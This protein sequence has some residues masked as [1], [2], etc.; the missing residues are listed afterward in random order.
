MTEKKTWDFIVVGSGAG[1]MCAALKMRAAGK[2]VLIIEK[3]ELLGGTTATSGGVMW[4]PNNRFM[5]EAGVS[6]CREDAIRYLDTVVGDSDSTP[7]TSSKR[8]AAYVDVSNEMLEFLID[9]GLQFRRVPSW[10]DYYEALGESI[11]GRTVAPELFDLN[12][13]GKEWKA[14]LRPGFIPA[15]AYLEEAMQLPNFKRSK[16]AKK[17]L[18]RVIGRTL[19]SRLRGKHLVTAGHALQGQMLHAAL[20][21]GIDIKINCAAKTLLQNGD[22]ISGV[23]AVIDGV[24]TELLSTHGVLINAG[25]FAQN[26]RMLDQ[27]LPLASSEWTNAS[28]GDTGEMIEECQRLG[29]ALAQMDERVGSPT[30]MLPGNPVFKPAMQGDLAKPHSI[31]VD[32]TAQRYMRESASY[33]TLSKAILERN[34]V[35]PALPSWMILD[36]NYIETYMLAGT[37]PGKKKPKEWSESKFLRQGDSIDELASACHLEPDALKQTVARF[38]KMV[39]QGKDDDFKRGDHAYDLWLGDDLNEGNATL[40]KIERAPFYAIKIYPGDLSTYGGVVTDEHARVLRAD[41]SAI[42]GLYATATSTASV[43]GRHTPGAGGSIGPGFTWAYAAA[44]HALNNN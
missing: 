16:P 24:E 28:P 40:G 17:I 14:K 26:Q 13:L 29:A 43:M 41:G 35:A 4:I 20:Q 12:K 15:P 8:R 22:R 32:Q 23:L 21:A 1:S 18:A 38:N 7:G 27:Y 19:W 34:A 11:P 36:Q 44:K 9:Q 31:V 30:V 42:S 10:P 3:T 33:M 5:K 37:M 2:S 6:D 39:E 25:G